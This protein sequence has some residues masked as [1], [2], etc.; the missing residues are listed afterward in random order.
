M[1]VIFILQY[2]NKLGALERSLCVVGM[3]NHTQTR[4]RGEQRRVRVAVTVT[5]KGE[6]KRGKERRPKRERAIRGETQQ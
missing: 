1:L 6:K 5:R 2:L 4:W 3:W